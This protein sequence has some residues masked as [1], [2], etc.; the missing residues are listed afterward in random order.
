[1]STPDGIINLF[2]PAGITSAKALYRV[3]A[4]THVRKSGHA[5]SLDP[6]AVGVVLV[7]QGRATKL[8][9][10][11]MDLPKVYRA[12]G[13]LDV[14]STSLDSD[15]R[16]EPVPI[17]AVPTEDAVRTAMTDF[18]GV[19]R[20]VPPRVSAVKLG[21]V[22]AYKT[23]GQVNAPPLPTREARIYWL[24]LHRYDWPEIDFEMACGRGTYVRS[25]I[26]D[27]GAQLGVGGCLTGL[28]RTAVGPFRIENA[29]TFEQMESVAAGTPYLIPLA[30][31]T[32]MIDRRPVEIPPRP[33]DDGE[34]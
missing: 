33:T 9:E 28:Q 2:K 22:P 25:L 23:V 18:E 19:I 12:T 5:G 34:A 4:I 10:R 20:Q 6:S 1:M 32:K 29:Q 11:I 16:L 14:T 26:R 31:A 17:P 27:L 13:R 24:H 15:S 7:C 3:R 21:G 8:V 30:E